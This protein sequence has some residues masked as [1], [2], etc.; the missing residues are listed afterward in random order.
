MFLFSDHIPINP[1]ASNKALEQFVEK[2][3][4]KAIKERT[5]RVLAQNQKILMKRARG[6]GEDGEAELDKP[7]AVREVLSGITGKKRADY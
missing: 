7:T 5:E 1:I 4:G 2:N 6:S 3:E